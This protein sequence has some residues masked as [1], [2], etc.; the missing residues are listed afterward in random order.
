M[1]DKAKNPKIITPFILFSLTAVAA[2]ILLLT[3]AI[4]WLGG[5]V[6]SLSLAALIVGGFLLIVSG[7]IYLISLRPALESINDR[8]ETIYNV[9]F[10][11]RNG[12]KVAHRYLISF[13]YDFLK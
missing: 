9:A 7:V 2:V 11:V 5:I 3:S 12:Y 4:I 8:M 13:F 1:D 10:A 6:D